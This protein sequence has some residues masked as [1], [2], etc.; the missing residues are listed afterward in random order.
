MDVINFIA[1][2]QADLDHGQPRSDSRFGDD[3]Q[4]RFES[5]TLFPTILPLHRGWPYLDQGDEIGMANAGFTTGTPWLAITPNHAT[6]N[7]ATDLAS[8]S[9]S[10][11]EFYRRLIAPRH[12]WSVLSLGDLVM[13]EPEHPARHA[14][15]RSLGGETLMVVGNFS[16]EPLELPLAVAGDQVIGNLVIGN[17]VIGDQVIGNLVIGNWGEI[18]DVAGAVRPWEVRAVRPG[19]VLARMR[20]RRTQ[21]YFCTTSDP[22]MRWAT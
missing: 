2:V 5:A 22:A 4:F 21:N 13:L 17:L 3:G 8:G 18:A 14:F 10:I 9:R 1:K 7:M 12:G 15:A 6:I 20:S 16:S 19:R 11:F